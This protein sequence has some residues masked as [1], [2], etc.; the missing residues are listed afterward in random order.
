MRKFI[1]I[2][3]MLI[4]FSMNSYAENSNI[5]NRDINSEKIENTKGGFPGL[6]GHGE[7]GNQT[8]PLGSGMLILGSLAVVYA[9][10]KNHKRS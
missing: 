7:T 5:F 10:S 2:V 8:A 3:F 1:M 9:F 4:M 6:P